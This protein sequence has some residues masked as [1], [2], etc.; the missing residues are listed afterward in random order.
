MSYPNKFCDL[1]PLPSVLLKA[2]IDSTGYDNNVTP[3]TDIV[4]DNFKETFQENNFAERYFEKI[5]TCF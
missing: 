3:R 4:L 2:C 1:D 5:S